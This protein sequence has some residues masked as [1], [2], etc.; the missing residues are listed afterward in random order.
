MSHDPVPTGGLAA[1]DRL[2][3]QHFPGTNSRLDRRKPHSGQK[4]EIRKMS[5]RYRN[6]S[7]G[8]IEPGGFLHMPCTLFVLIS[9]R[10]RLRDSSFQ[11]LFVKVNREFQRCPKSLSAWL[12]SIS[13]SDPTIDLAGDRLNRKRDRLGHCVPRY[14]K[15]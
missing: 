15:R 4:R 3:P 7:G 6:G 12:K 14:G 1:L 10:Q 13:V 5:R 8:L 11:I 2:D 9:D